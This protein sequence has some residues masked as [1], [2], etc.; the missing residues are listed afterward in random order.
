VNQFLKE[1]VTSRDAG[2]IT[3][4]SWQDYK[5]ACGLIVPHFGTGRLLD[6][7]GP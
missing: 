4:R 5:D 7:I 3:P 1:K 2:E 6:D